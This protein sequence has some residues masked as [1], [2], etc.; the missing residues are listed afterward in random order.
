[1]VLVAQIYDRESTT[2]TESVYQ[3][4]KNVTLVFQGVDLPEKYEVIFS[5]RKERGISISCEG[6][7]VSGVLIP[8]QLLSTGDY[9]YAWVCETDEETGRMTRCPV[10]IPVIPRPVPIPIQK[11]SGED[12]PIITNYDIDP[13]NENLSFTGYFNNILDNNKEEEP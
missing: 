2:Y 12:V 1:M 6:N 3:H 11:G 9:V 7:G 5:D 4:D 10:V 8:D 13:E